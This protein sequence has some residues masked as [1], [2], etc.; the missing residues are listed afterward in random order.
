LRT[1]RYLR[2]YLQCLTDYSKEVPATFPKG[3]T[4]L[5]LNEEVKDGFLT[6]VMP[7]LQGR[8]DGI[9]VKVYSRVGELDEGGGGRGRGAGGDDDVIYDLRLKTF[10]GAP[11]GGA[12]RAAGGGA[13][14][15][16]PPAG[17][18][19]PGSF[20]EERRSSGGGLKD[21]IQMKLAQQRR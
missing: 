7:M 8:Q 20:Q 9:T 11:G 1:R 12:A 18:G 5:G 6:L 10:R 4:L 21:R 3:I 2:L 13:A 16:A 17:G 19:G 15:A 14:A